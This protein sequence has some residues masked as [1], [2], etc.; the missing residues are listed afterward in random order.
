MLV[1]MWFLKEKD[2]QKT[3]KLHSITDYI[4][5]KEQSSNRTMFQL[6]HDYNALPIQGAVE[7]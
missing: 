5:F 4:Y 1:D 7:F 2:K 3:R 6:V